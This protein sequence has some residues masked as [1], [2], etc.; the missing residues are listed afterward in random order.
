MIAEKPNPTVPRPLDGHH[1]RK[2][3]RLLILHL[4]VCRL[5]D[6]DGREAQT[7][8]VSAP[9]APDDH[10]CGE[11]VSRRVGSGEVSSVL[12]NKC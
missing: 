11:D 1:F 9:R 10:R 7:Q 6:Y 2:S 8:H 3:Y 12:L 5:S 4:V